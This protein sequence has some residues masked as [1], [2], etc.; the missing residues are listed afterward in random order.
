MPKI[1]FV[2]DTGYFAAKDDGSRDYVKIKA[3][4]V[5][6]V[7]EA[8]AARWERRDV[9]ERVREPVA[10]VHAAPPP[11]PPPAPPAPPQVPESRPEP[12]NPP[13]PPPPA[14][15]TMVSETPNAG[16]RGRPSQETPPGSETGNDG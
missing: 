14:A 5:Q 11:P 7:T 9:I 1:R 15:M 10:G 4:T 2:V 12:S 6:D 8:T 16:R 13:A 3:G